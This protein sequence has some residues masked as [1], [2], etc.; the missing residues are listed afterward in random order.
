MN[1]I[2]NLNVVN[3]TRSREEWIEFSGLPEELKAKVM[4]AEVI[5]LPSLIPD[6]PKAFMTGT[7]DLYALLQTKF[8]EKAE[9]CIADEDYV[10]IELNSRVLRIG[11]ILVLSV[12]LPLLLNI[13]GNYIYD[14][15]KEPNI[16]QTEIVIQEFQQP[17]TVSF[18]IAVEDTLGKKKEFHYEGPATEYKEVANE[19]E[20]LWNED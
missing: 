14:R 20:K 16:N 7:M 10:E 18:T 19:I 11:K 13:L 5:V 17:A 9:I 8:G 1:M 12:A 6:N 3:V 4:A 15:I 2:N